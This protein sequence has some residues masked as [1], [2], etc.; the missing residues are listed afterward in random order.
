MGAHITP[1]AGSEQAPH[2]QTSR[3][4]SI[5]HIKI[6]NNAQ[7]RK[8]NIARCHLHPFWAK[9]VCGTLVQSSGLSGLADDR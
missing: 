9:T 2:Y 4:F 3:H 6:A 5:K 7:S 8:N 1:L